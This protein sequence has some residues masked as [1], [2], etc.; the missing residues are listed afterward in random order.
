[1]LDFMRK[2]LQI[3]ILILFFFSPTVSAQSRLNGAKIIEVSSKSNSW[4]IDKGRYEGISVGDTASFFLQTS[5]DAPKLIPLGEAEAV[6]VHGRNSYWILTKSM[7]QRFY[8]RGR[9]IVY[10][11]DDEIYKGRRALKV[12]Q[13]NI[14][15]SKKYPKSKRRLEKGDLPNQYKKKDSDYKKSSELV[16]VKKDTDDDRKVMIFKKAKRGKDVRAVEGVDEL[17]DVSAIRDQEKKK[18]VYST[19]TGVARKT[20]NARFG[21]R[22]LYRDNLDKNGKEKFLGDG[23][24]ASDYNKYRA[25]QIEQNDTSTRA[26]KR[27]T[28][29]SKLWSADLNDEE[30]RRFFIS[31]GFARERKKQLYALE[32]KIGNEFILRYYFGVAEHTASQDV[33]ASNND[34]T[35]IGSNFSISFGYEYYLLRTNPNLVNWSLD[36]FID[37]ESRYLQDEAGNNAESTEVNFAFGVNYYFFNNPASLSKVL[38]FVGGGASLGNAK[39][40]S[41]TSGI[42]QSYSVRGLPRV[43]IG[44]KYRLKAGDEYDDMLGMG[45]GMHATLMTENVVY[46]SKV[47][48]NVQTNN[49]NIQDFKF[50][51]GISLIF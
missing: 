33:A 1:M 4:L 9:K 10:L 45:F 25:E 16:E 24:L 36:F 49:I 26:R 11:L 19:V 32:H 47:N 48:E 13:R 51:L 39:L 37:N 7:N 6:K 31:S 3:S 41:I 20:N 35:A 40:L 28:R 18:V 2:M 8:S 34:A 43:W 46:A 44:A 21:L 15:T 23:A 12:K 14:V 22:S 29:D 38:G 42:E 17:I 5:I 30:L 50:A 27:I